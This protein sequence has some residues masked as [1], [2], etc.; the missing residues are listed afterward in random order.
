MDELGSIKTGKTPPA[1]LGP[2]AFG[3]SIPFVTPGDLGKEGVNRSLSALGARNAALV[4]EGSLLVCCIGATIGKMG[5]A[6]QRS[7]FNQQINAVEWNETI[8]PF[9]GFQAARLLKSKII[10]ASTSTTMPILNKTSFSLLT[11]PVPPLELQQTF[12]ARAAA[13]ERLKEIHR[14]H[15]AELDTLF[16]SLQHRAFKGEL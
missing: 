9:Y 10:A 8:H 15:L 14:K 12:A 11:L 7:S 2:E 4:A 13:V 3:G 16:A 1:K 6:A 5:I